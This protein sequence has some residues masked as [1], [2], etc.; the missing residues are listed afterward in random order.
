MTPDPCDLIGEEGQATIRSRLKEQLPPLDEAKFERLV[1]AI[2]Q[3]VGAEL[4]NTTREERDCW[5]LQRIGRP[6]RK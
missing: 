6:C 1:L 3:V 4:E 5:F 2:L